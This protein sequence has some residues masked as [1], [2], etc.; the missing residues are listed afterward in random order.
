MSR[1]GILDI[2]SMVRTL[3]SLSELSIESADDAIN[4]LIKRNYELMDKHEADKNKDTIS[5][6]KFAEYIPTVFVSFKIAIDMMLV[7]SNYL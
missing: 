5:T 1:F 7:V 2:S 3:Y 6:M 4:S